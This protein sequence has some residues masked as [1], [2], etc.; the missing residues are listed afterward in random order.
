MANAPRRAD[1]FEQVV[2]LDEKNEKGWFWLASVVDTDEERR[3]CLSNVLHI[4]PN[5]ERAKRALDALQAKAKEQKTAAE[6]EE[7]VAGVTRRQMTLIIGIGVVAVIVILIIALTVIVGNNNRRS[8]ERS[9]ATGGRA[10]AT[11][12]ALA[13]TAAAD[14]A[15]GTS[16]AATATQQAIGVTPIDTPTALVPTLP[17]TWTPTPLATLPPTREALPLPIGLTGRLALWGGQD[18][19]SIGYLPLGYYDFDLGTQFNPIGNS[20]GQDITFAPSGDRVVYTV[21]DE[22]LFSSSLE[23]INLNGTQI[24]SLPDRWRGQNI[25]SP[26]KPRYGGQFRQYMV[27]VAATDKR[28]TTQVFLL[29]LNAPAGSSA[30][31]QMT[32]DDDEYTYPALSPDGSKIAVVRHVS[33][34]A[35]PTVDI[36]SIDVQQ[37][38]HDPDHQ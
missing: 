33:N 31:R 24:E 25:F 34:T 12:N 29:D 37:R 36:V 8:A 20:F 38:G 30:V 28:Q 1:F 19:L 32:D 23:A 13:A 16:V 9:T 21:Y 22:L 5:N 14:Q 17:P 6:A 27:F 4:N 26:Q 15:T 18:M 35:N 2:E 11:N 3:I 10:V 7:V